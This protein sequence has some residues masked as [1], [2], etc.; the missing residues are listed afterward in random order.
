V[1]AIDLRFDKVDDPAGNNDTENAAKNMSHGWAVP[2]AQQFIRSVLEAYPDRQISIVGHSFGVT[3]TRDAL[4]RLHNEGMPVWSRIEDLVFLAGANHGVST[5]RLCNTNPTM[6]GEV[7]CEMGDRAAFSPTPFLSAING[8]DGEWETPCGDGTSAYGDD[9][10]CGDHYVSYTT[11][12]MQD[13][14]DG[15]QQD[16]FVSEESARLQGA[17]NLTIGLNEFDESDYFFCGFLKNHFGP[18]RSLAAL[19]LIVSRLSD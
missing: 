11:I 4:R 10:A 8:A 16:E 13:L 2:I 9:Q 6:R 5:H 15:T 17:E 3:Y 19:D 7:T 12:V 18:A 1:I 14:P